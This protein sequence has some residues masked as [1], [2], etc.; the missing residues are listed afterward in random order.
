MPLTEPGSSPPDDGCYG[1]IQ[2]RRS[3]G[4][5]GLA[6]IACTPG[7]EPPLAR[8]RCGR[9]R[10]P[11]E[12]QRDVVSMRTPGSVNAALDG[13]CMKPSRTAAAARAIRIATTH[14]TRKTRMEPSPDSMHQCAAYVGRAKA[15][16]S[17]FANAAERTDA[18]RERCGSGYLPE[19]LRGQISL[20][21]DIS[22]V[23]RFLR[24]HS[25]PAP[26]RA[27]SRAPPAPEA[28]AH[29]WSI[30]SRHPRGQP[31]SRQALPPDR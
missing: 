6:T 31:R 10:R 17:I 27:P 23:H 4:A 2:R 19:T 9:G 22:A 15:S 26:G 13:S 29:L 8:H 18:C 28:D 5:A 3:W 24:S 1:A 11:Y 14:A 21:V 30:R 16:A 25:C 12:N 7:R 20:V